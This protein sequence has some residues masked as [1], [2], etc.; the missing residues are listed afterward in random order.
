MNTIRLPA[1]GTSAGVAR[2]HVVALLSEWGVD[3]RVRDD[4]VLVV[5]ELVSNVI[6]H[7]HGSDTVVC[8]VL[9]GIDSLHIEVAAEGGVRPPRQRSARSGDESGRGLLLVNALCTSWGVED[10]GASS[11]WTVW[12]RLPREPQAPGDG[13]TPASADAE[14][15]PRNAA[16][17]PGNTQG[18]HAPPLR[19]HRSSGASR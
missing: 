19:T 11:G 9:D 14:T 3:S 17:S 5:S 6:V 13:W 10:G 16:A 15:S 7:A 8:Q 18:A 4:A 12:V 2:K 1:R